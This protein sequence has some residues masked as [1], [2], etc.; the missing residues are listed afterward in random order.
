M[1]GVWGASGTDVFAVGENGTILNLKANLPVPV[2]GPCAR[3]VSI[4]CET[5]LFGNNLGRPAAFDSYACGSRD[6]TGQEVYYKLHNPVTGQLTVRLTPYEE[7]LD[8][9]VVGANAQTGCDPVGQ[10]LAASQTID[11]AMEEVTLNVIAGQTY[12]FIVDGYAGA[13]SDYTIEVDC[14]K[15]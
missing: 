8:L 12:Y 14:R 3:P 6:D 1:R 11:T 10:C 4:Y 13:E 7:D 5:T 9:I 15:E 2:G